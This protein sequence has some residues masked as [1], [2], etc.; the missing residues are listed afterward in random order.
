MAFSS[1]LLATTYT[2]TN[3]ADSGA[4]S[5]RQ[6]ITDANTN[7]GIDTISFNIPTTEAT[8]E[9]GATF[10]RI[11][12]S[13]N[14]PAI[15][16]TV[17]IDGTTQPT[18]ET[19][20]NPY[21]PEIMLDGANVGGSPKG[22]YITTNECVVK[23]LIIDNFR[24]GGYGILIE[25][26]NNNR[27]Y[28]CYI[29]TDATGSSYLSNYNAE[30]I[31]IINLLTNHSQSNIIGSTESANINI[32]SGNA[33]NGIYIRSSDN[34]E[35][36]GNIIG[37]TATGE[38]SIGNGQRGINIYSDS[39][40]NKIGNGAAS[41]RNIIS[42]NPIGVD[43]N[44]TGNN[45]TGN[46]I[47][48]NYIGTNV[49]G[50]VALGNATYGVGMWGG[51]QSNTIG[52]VSAGVGNVISGNSD[53]VH[54]SD[55]NNSVLGNYIG[56]N[57]SGTAALGNTGYGIEINAGA[58]NNKIGSTE[59]GGRNI[60]SGNGEKG[61]YITGSGTNS[62]EVIGN[63][64]GTAADGIG[65]FGDQQ[66]YGVDIRSGASYNII[67]GIT[68]AA[69]NIIAGN[70]YGGVYIYGAGTE[71]NKIKAN[72]IGLR[73]DG[74]GLANGYYS[75]GGV[76]IESGNYNII[77]GITEGERNIISSNEAGGGITLS[78]ANSNEVLGN[79]IGTNAN[80]TSALANTPY[81]IKIRDGSSNNKIGSIESGGRNII[82]GN[83][84]YGIY[85][86]DA[87]SDSN[88]VL[89]NYIGTTASG[90]GN[91][92]NGSIGVV[93]DSAANYNRVGGVNTGERNVISGNAQ[94]G[95]Y[96]TSTSNE[97]LGNYIGTSSDGN[98][99]L[100]NNWGIFISNPAQ[101]NQIGSTESGGRNIISGNTTDGVYLSGS[102]TNYNRI[103][104]NYIG[105][106]PGGN[107]ANEGNGRYG[108]M[109]R[110]SAYYNQ[111]GDG[112]AA[113]R[114][115]ISA[116]NTVNGVGIAI[117]TN[118]TEVS[119]NYVG[120]DPTGNI[121]LGNTSG[122][123]LTGGAKY[124]R[125]SGNLVSGN[126]G[127]SGCGIGFASAGTN[128]NEVVGNFIGTNAAGNGNLSNNGD[129]IYFYNGPQFNKIGG[130]ATSEGNIISGNKKNGIYMESSTTGS[131]EVIGNYIG[132]GASGAGV[133]G[134]D[135]C[136]I[137][138]VSGASNNIIGPN[139]V[140]AN[141]GTVYGYGGIYISGTNT[142]FNRIT[143]NSIFDNRF[144]GI[145]LWSGGNSSEAVPIISSAVYDPVSFLTTVSG[146]SDAGT[147]IEVFS[148]GAPD[149]TGSGEGRTYRTSTLANGGGTWSVDIAGL[150]VGST[151]T[152][153]A[154]DSNK[155][156]SMFSVNKIVTESG[157]P[158]VEVTSPAGAE[159]W[160][161]GSS[162]SITFLAT[163]ESG[164]KP[165]SADLYYNSGEGWVTIATGQPTDSPYPWTL[166]LISSAEVKVKVAV[167]D[168][169]D[170]TGTDESN[171]FFTIDS[172]SPSPPTLVTPNNG[173]FINYANPTLTWEAATDPDNLTGIASYEINFNGV[174]ITRDATTAYVASSLSDGIYTWEVKARDGAGNWGSYSSAW[175]F[176]IDSTPPNAPVL[177]TP[178]NM[179]T[180]SAR[181][182]LMTW[183]AST[184]NLSGIS[185]YEVKLDN[186]SY[187]QDATASYTPPSPL[188]DGAHT[189]EVRAKNGVGLWGD[190]SS[191]FSFNIE[192]LT[193]EVSGITLSDLETGS[194]V[195]ARNRTVSLEANGVGGNPVDMLISE[196][197][198]FAG[199]NW[200]TYQNPV[201]ID[202]TSTEGTKE[203][204]Y[205]LRNAA[206]TESG[207]VNDLI[208]LDTTEPSIPTLEAPANGS[209]VE[210]STPT[211]SWEAATDNLSGVIS[212]EAKLDLTYHTQEAVTHYTT[213]PLTPGI[214]S[215]EV[216]AKDAAGNWGGYS[217]TWDF[218]VVTAT[219][220][221]TT[222]T[223]PGTTTTTTTTT[224]TI[225]YPTMVILTAE[226]TVNAIDV[227]WE[228]SYDP[229]PPGITSYILLRGRKSS[230][231][232]EIIDDFNSIS[233]N[234]A[235][236]GNKVEI[237]TTFTPDQR[238]GKLNITSGPLVGDKDNISVAGYYTAVSYEAK[239]R[240]IKISADVDISK[241]SLLHDTKNS[242]MLAGP[243]IMAGSFDAFALPFLGKTYTTTFP[244][245]LF[246]G[247]DPRTVGTTSDQSGKI[248]GILAGEG[249]SLFLDNKYLGL[250]IMEKGSDLPHYYGFM[251]LV[252]TTAATMDVDFDNF[253]AGEYPVEMVAS[254][255]ASTLFYHDRD[256][257]VGETYFYAVSP[258]SVSGKS[259]SN[260]AE[261]QL[262]TTTTTT[263]STSTT[264]TTTTTLPS[265]LSGF[266]R[267]SPV[268]RP[269]AALN[270]DFLAKETGNYTI[271]IFYQ[272]TGVMVRD[273]PFNT[274]P[275]PNRV[276]WR[277]EAG[278][279]KIN[280]G[281]DAPPGV[282]YYEIRSSQTGGLIT[283]G[284]FVVVKTI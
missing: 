253:Y 109:V 141:N 263:T 75:Y 167:Q 108:I 196:E 143:L 273:I 213:D 56:T 257:I 95:I 200:L 280:T 107:A 192:T 74:T 124:N 84:S 219:T 1:P 184:D 52:G 67:G 40:N 188:A 244:G 158:S 149:P 9:A 265:G 208:I 70:S 53:G 61:I 76:Y 266:S 142:V 168:I 140:I 134:N 281:E 47:A 249:L 230:A 223:V 278:A 245:Y 272:S 41:G 3:C 58:K 91:L 284:N 73:A 240:F 228:A 222:T 163:D 130:I 13:S 131:N 68:S 194:T 80:G 49:S 98:S 15:T 30:G 33:G 104:G 32:I 146:T 46:V 27:I 121:S 159:Q 229:N 169:Y 83:S 51:A 186:I 77:G 119:G 234:S 153:T 60:I 185:S 96:I 42:G 189:W 129:G 126:T 18:S 19:Y 172:I 89:G 132:T 264:S 261:A 101:Y 190:Y 226:A 238:N 100:A 232:V 198:D 125:I 274:V 216:R 86:S 276:S 210:T 283:W 112:T 90:E 225:K 145:S 282:Y 176:T 136:G 110:S 117:W 207:A 82:S 34:N 72:Y 6:A 151:L 235:L 165:N 111:I 248:S 43:I 171:A 242:F 239:P 241:S 254:L 215:W 105:L 154:T 22:L 258:N 150:T 81:G 181:Q 5:L 123:F 14:L 21:G 66:D 260:V 206:S 103:I 255:D 116:N 128:S 231:E 250:F 227:S 205:K 120:T 106:N 138:L 233:F 160:Q 277:P 269:G 85:I 182:P 204:Y 217:T 236:W 97:V 137:Y 220:T 214:H 39:T 35:V 161:G 69:R 11:K 25:G 48:G 29:G 195:Y 87:G 36:L 37:L 191:S 38:A 94:Y 267:V 71:G 28:G 133:I 270:I 2:V 115:I 183:E 211:L 170:N 59:S 175:D 157:P 99:P 113:G 135:N 178:A 247:E 93:I 203:V 271:F 17:I 12:P 44:G 148:T 193:P 162:R 63:Y 224:T 237:G 174:L 144:L 279:L 114:N 246:A 8:T 251:T 122:I 78:G 62:N 155:N 20:N 7:A 57:A 139:N 54:L 102:G 218:T 256:V 268:L 45:P 177:I 201:V 127:N 202:L 79:Y 65:D 16:G 50:T 92:G 275:G 55:S 88:E 10:W 64:I 147:T 259:G 156:T 221:T 152:A 187:T 23:S 166:P 179:I 164:I 180:I 197:A 173:A 31:G 118:S 243:I 252:G 212:Y 4:G 26:G 209:T 24:I 199:A 262:T